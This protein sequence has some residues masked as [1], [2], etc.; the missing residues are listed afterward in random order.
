MRARPGERNLLDDD[1]VIRAT[2]AAQRAADLDSPHTEIEMPPPRRPDPGVIAD[3]RLERAMRTEQASA[4]QH[5]RDHDQPSEP[6]D[7]DDI[8]I[9]ETQQALEYG[10]DAHG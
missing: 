3:R 1:A 5:R 4:A 7:I 2:K 8:D 6:L 10:S 9:I